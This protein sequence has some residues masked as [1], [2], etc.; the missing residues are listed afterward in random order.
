MGEPVRVGAD[1]DDV[2]AEGEPIHDGGAK[3]WVGE[4]CRPA[5]EQFVGGDSDGVLS[6]RSGNTSKSCSA[7]R[8][9]SSM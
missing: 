5:G 9:S 7:P 3:S 1:F 2:V 6:S 4:H 8:L